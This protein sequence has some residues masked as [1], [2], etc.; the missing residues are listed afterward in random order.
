M[1]GVLGERR[2][3]P[4]NGCPWYALLRASFE[5]AAEAVVLEAVLCHCGGIEKIAA[6]EDQRPAHGFRD[7]GPVEIT[8]FG[9]LGEHEQ[10]VGAAGDAVRIFAELDLRENGGGSG[11]GFLSVGAK[12]GSF[13]EQAADDFERR[14]KAN[15]VG[16]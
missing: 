5:A 12:V 14:R 2:G 1:L 9:P 6:V 16:V 7:A 10:S 15:V 8:K 13:G 11:H 4:E 3:F